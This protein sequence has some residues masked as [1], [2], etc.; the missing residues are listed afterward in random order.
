MAYVQEINRIHEHNQAVITRQWRVY[1]VI[2]IVLFVL[3]VIL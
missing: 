1:W 3:A 2:L